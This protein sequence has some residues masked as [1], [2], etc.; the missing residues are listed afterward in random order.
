MVV[1]F[2]RRLREE[3]RKV[4]SSSQRRCRAGT[5]DT[6]RLSL[7][8]VRSLEFKGSVTAREHDDVA[9]FFW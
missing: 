7:D 6:V 8:S 4:Q 1:E 9:E 2:S 5:N 3:L